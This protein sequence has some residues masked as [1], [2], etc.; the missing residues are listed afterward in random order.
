MGL[1]VARE[2]ALRCGPPSRGNTHVTNPPA[3]LSLTS[4]PR[5]IRPRIEQAKLPVDT[6]ASAQVS[7]SETARLLD[8]L[9]TQP[10]TRATGFEIAQAGRSHKPVSVADRLA[11]NSSAGNLSPGETGPPLSV[12]ESGVLTLHAIHGARRNATG[13]R[14]FSM[15]VPTVRGDP[16]FQV[17]SGVTFAARALSDVLANGAFLIFSNC[18]TRIAP[19][20]EHQPRQTRRSENASTRLECFSSYSRDSSA[21]QVSGVPKV[22]KFKCTPQ[23][24]V[25]KGS[26]PPRQACT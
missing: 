19:E 26:K 8:P 14:E 5:I 6:T 21:Q 4:K 2:L 3:R 12:F 7:F 16:I 23:Y 15:R 18:L 22:N 17:V 11:A 20:Y 25:V 1:S 10:L 9:G 13:G 24:Y